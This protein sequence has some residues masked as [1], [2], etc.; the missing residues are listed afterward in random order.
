M[1]LNIQEKIKVGIVSD[2]HGFI[3]PRIIDV[4]AKCDIAVHAGDIG[5][6]NSLVSLETRLGYIT[7]VRGN[8]D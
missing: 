7:A 1:N 3:D 5:N 6:A 4:V 8:N 2:T